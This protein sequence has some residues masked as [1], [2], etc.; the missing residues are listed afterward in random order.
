LD[1][2]DAAGR[3]AKGGDCDALECEFPAL[4]LFRILKRLSIA[5][6]ELPH[7]PSPP[8]VTIVVSDGSLRD[9]D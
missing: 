6:A 9:S 2:V 7:A 4:S 1:G 3:A 8:I 5:G